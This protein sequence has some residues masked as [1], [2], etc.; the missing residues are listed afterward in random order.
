MI[1][2]FKQFF[3]I[4]DTP[5]KIAAGAALGVFLG[6]APGAGIAATLVLASVFRFNRIAAVA[7][8]VAT[9]TWSLIFALPLAAALGGWL[10][11]YN[12]TT[13]IEQFDKIYNLGFAFLLRKEILFDIV[14]PLAVGFIAV[15]AIFAFVFYILTFLL[16]KKF[17]KP[18]ST[19]SHL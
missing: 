14:A 17:R 15:S 18:S 11:G 8:A 16:V 19:E 12:R 4:D 13:L 5:H 9:N 2:F 10:F 1:K 3:L 7:S 6:I